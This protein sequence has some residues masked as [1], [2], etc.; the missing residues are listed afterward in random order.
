MRASSLQGSEWLRCGRIAHMAVC[1]SVCYSCGGGDRSRAKS[2]PILMVAQVHL[3]KRAQRS[4]LSFWA[5]HTATQ[6]PKLCLEA[7]VE[8]IQ[9]SGECFQGN[10][11][12]SLHSSGS[13]VLNIIVLL[14]QYLP[15]E[16]T[17]EEFTSSVVLVYVCK[18]QHSEG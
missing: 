9:S 4:E 17:Q 10:T 3:C 18:S 5:P 13:D 2:F 14:K 12:I 6:P 16:I 15:G 7:H 1:V 8:C 11:G